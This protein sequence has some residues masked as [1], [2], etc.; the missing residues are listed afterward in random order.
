[1]EQVLRRIINKV[2]E[3]VNPTVGGGGGE[4]GNFSRNTQSPITSSLCQ[5]G[6]LRG[7]GVG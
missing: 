7:G 2:R 4:E 1:M 3:E 5:R 6:S